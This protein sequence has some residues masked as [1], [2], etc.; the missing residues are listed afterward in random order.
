MV[1][2]ITHWQNITLLWYLVSVKIDEPVEFTHL[3]KLRTLFSADAIIGEILKPDEAGWEEDED[4]SL[5]DNNSPF[6]KK[7]RALSMLG[8]KRS[9]RRRRSQFGMQ[10]IVCECCHHRCGLFEMTQYCS[11]DHRT[12]DSSFVKRR[13]AVEGAGARHDD[14]D[15]EKTFSLLQVLLQPRRRR[16]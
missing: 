9:M 4:Q 12:D 16:K 3:L 14:V 1:V 8:D 6:L 2:I 5:D 11:S 15:N 10:G 13:S 7:S